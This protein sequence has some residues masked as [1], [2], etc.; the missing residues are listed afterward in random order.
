MQSKVW[1][2]TIIFISICIMMSCTS[3]QENKDED[4]NLNTLCIE[5]DLLI[6]LTEAIP[7]KVKVVE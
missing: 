3:N 6:E 2:K 1:I 4:V 5:P 7:A